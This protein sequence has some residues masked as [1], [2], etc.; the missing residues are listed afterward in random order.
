MTTQDPLPS[1][2]YP[3]GES[4]MPAGGQTRDGRGPDRVVTDQPD[5]DF[6]TRPLGFAPIAR[7]RRN[8]EPDATSRAARYRLA[9]PGDHALRLAPTPGVHRRST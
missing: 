8:V 5:P 4:Y 3:W 1:V 9:L 2:R 6:T 7:H